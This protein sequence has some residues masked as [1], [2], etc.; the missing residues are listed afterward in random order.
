MKKHHK[1]Y[2]YMYKYFMVST[3]SFCDK[4]NYDI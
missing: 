4:I 2:I 3:E 1:K